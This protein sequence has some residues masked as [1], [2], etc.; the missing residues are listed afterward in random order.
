MMSSSDGHEGCV[1][2]LLDAGAEINARD[3]VSRDVLYA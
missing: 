2:A 3:A 1:K